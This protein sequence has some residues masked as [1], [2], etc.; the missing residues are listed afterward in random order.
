MICET[1]PSSLSGVA[2]LSIGA[3]S[4]P[5][6]RHPDGTRCE[7]RKGGAAYPGVDVETRVR[8]TAA[9]VGVAAGCR[10]RAVD[11][12]SALRHFELGPD[13][14]DDCSQRACDVRICGGNHSLH[15]SGFDFA[16]GGLANGIAD[17]PRLRLALPQILSAVWDRGNTAKLCGKRGNPRRSKRQGRSKRLPAGSM[18][19]RLDPRPG[20]HW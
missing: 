14:A 7:A 12:E 1:H 5:A 8:R 15:P 4:R 18:D 3:V 16:N 6:N 19:C 11:F 2:A 10:R 20:G 17:L 9:G 13:G